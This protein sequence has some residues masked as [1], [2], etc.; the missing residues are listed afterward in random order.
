MPTLNTALAPFTKLFSSNASGSS[1]TA[2]TPTTTKPSGDGVVS[3]VASGSDGYNGLA[4]AFY[5]TRSAA[6]N[7]TMTARLTGWRLVG[8]LWVPVPLLALAITQGT[9]VGVAGADVVATEYFADTIT[10]ST[11]FTSAN[12]IINPA[13]NTIALV[14]VDF[15]GF[16]LIQVQLAKGTNATCN[17]LAAG[18]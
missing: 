3:G 10:A 13:D 16:Q 11:A 9:S 7:E 12:E 14:K 5:G 18:F 15:C 1:I 4:L 17:C 8:T 2:P 6:D